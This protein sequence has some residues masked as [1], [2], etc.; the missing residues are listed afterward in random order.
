MRR[1][2]GTTGRGKAKVLT[3]VGHGVDARAICQEVRKLKEIMM[4]GIK[5]WGYDPITGGPI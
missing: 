1:L 2:L 4:M 3:R 5:I